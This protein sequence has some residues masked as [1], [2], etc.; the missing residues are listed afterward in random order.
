[1]IP[2]KDTLRSR[3]F[4]FVLIGLVLINA[5]VFVEQVRAGPGGERLIQAFGLVPARL[6]HWTGVGG[7]SSWPPRFLPLV[8]SMF[9]HG[10]LLHLLGNLLY[11]WVFGAAIEGKLGHARFASFYLLC[12]LA[13][14]GLQTFFAPGSTVP[15]IGASGAIAGVLGGYLVAFPHAR[16]IT[17]VPLWFIPWLIQVP[18]LVFLL[19]WFGMQMFAALAGLGR[20]FTGGVAFWAHVGGFVTGALLMLAWG[21]RGRRGRR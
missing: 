11:L 18:A 19:L 5:L 20:D 8:T 3:T 4:P 9:F 14:A 16:V 13:A 7:L 15:M 21:P 1:M 17:L 10:G 12:G 2:L 6:T